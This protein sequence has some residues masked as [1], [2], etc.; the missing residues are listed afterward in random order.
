MQIVSTQAARLDG[1]HGIASESLLSD[2]TEVAEKLRGLRVIHVNAT[3]QGGGVAEILK[4]L[5]PLMQDVGVKAEWYA[6][7]P[8]DSFFIYSLNS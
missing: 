3:A 2:V 1:Y 8:E 7:L 4:S 6:L 5:V